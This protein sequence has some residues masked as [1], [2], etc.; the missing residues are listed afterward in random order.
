MFRMKAKTFISRLYNS[1]RGD[2]LKSFA[3]KFNELLDC[4]DKQNITV[5]VISAYYIFNSLMLFLVG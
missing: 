5:G 3:N 1:F 4:L 2:I